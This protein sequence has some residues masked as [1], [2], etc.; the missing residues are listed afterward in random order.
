M[1]VYMHDSAWSNVELRS[2]IVVIKNRHCDCSSRR[3]WR[4]SRVNGDD[5]Q[6]MNVLQ[7]SVQ[8]PTQQLTSHS[9]DEEITRY[10]T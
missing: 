10:V 1:C 3:E 4:M 7:F 6:A 9:V 2:M 8:R 5:C